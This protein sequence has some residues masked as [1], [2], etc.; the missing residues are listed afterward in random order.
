MHSRGDNEDDFE[1]VART[2]P[3]HGRADPLLVLSSRSGTMRKYSTIASAP[4]ATR[5]ARTLFWPFLEW[6][7]ISEMPFSTT[8]LVT[9]RLTPPLC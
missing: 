7:K 3:H 4:R 9:T 5:N 2:N 1:W 8:E 6:R